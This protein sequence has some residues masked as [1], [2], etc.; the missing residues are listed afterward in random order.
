LDITVTNIEEMTIATE[1]VQLEID[2]T[3]VKIDIV[4][5][6]RA[7]D[8]SENAWI[9]IT[10][11]MSLKGPKTTPKSWLREPGTK[12]YIRELFNGDNSAHLN[13]TDEMVENRNV[14]PNYPKIYGRE[15][16]DVKKGRYGGT[17]VHKD[18]FLEF[19]SWISVKFRVASHKMMKEVL[20]STAQIKAERTSTKELFHPLVEAI[21][22]IYVPRQGYVDY[23]RHRS[24][25]MDMINKKVLGLRAKE[26]R[27]ANKLPSSG[28]VRDYLNADTLDKIKTLERHMHGLIYYAKITD[29]ATLKSK[30]QVEIVENPLKEEYILPKGDI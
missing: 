13:I 23:T 7:S 25:L 3:E 20:L 28:D 27:A 6:L 2:G 26:F 10:P 18:L 16:V 4:G 9:N 21:D 12:A 15:V 19:S 14:L 8:D 5:L 17:W 1:L 22:E 24:Q 29:Y 11:M 30:L